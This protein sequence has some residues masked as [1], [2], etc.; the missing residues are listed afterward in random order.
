MVVVKLQE[1]TQALLDDPSLGAHDIDGKIRQLLQAEYM[2]QLAHYRRVDNKLAKKYGMHF[3]DFIAQ[4]ISKVKNFSWDV[5]QD[6]M[7]WET[8]IG[9][10]QTVKRKLNKVRMLDDEH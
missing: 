9:G 2:R 6:A 1:S 7:K 3:D 8:A 5:E 10:I 4:R